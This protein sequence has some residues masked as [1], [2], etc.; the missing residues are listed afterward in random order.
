MGFRAM[1]PTRNE[2]RGRTFPRSDFP[3]RAGGPG[4]SLPTKVSTESGKKAP[5]KNFS[6]HL[7]PRNCYAGAAK[8]TR[9]P[10]GARENSPRTARH[11]AGGEGG[12]GRR[13]S[14]RQ[15]GR[16]EGSQEHRSEER[17]AGMKR[18]VR[19]ETTRGT[20]SRR[21]RERTG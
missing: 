17:D 6:N 3:E 14:L 2:A 1:Q 4:C 11:E 15:G 10:S 18:E 21:D 5:L 19:S 12:L 13:S 7:P 20:R 9:E 8:S 16:K